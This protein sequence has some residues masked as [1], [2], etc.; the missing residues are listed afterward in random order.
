MGS[1]G[2]KT[3]PWC[4]CHAFHCFLVC[5]GAFTWEQRNACQLQQ[6]LLWV[7]GCLLSSK[8]S[9]WVGWGCNQ[10]VHNWTNGE[11]D[12]AARIPSDLGSLFHVCLFP[13][14]EINWK[15]S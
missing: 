2:Q 4:S 10:E 1:S 12:P 15:T 6:E 9:S 13:P 14:L 11:E 3:S 7:L 5:F 8:M